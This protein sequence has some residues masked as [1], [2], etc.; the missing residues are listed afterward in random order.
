MKSLCTLESVLTV[1][2]L[3][4][5]FC[6]SAIEAYGSV[7]RSVEYLLLV[8]IPPCRECDQWAGL[9]SDDADWLSGDGHQD[10]PHQ[11]LVSS[12]LPPRSAEESNQHLLWFSS[13]SHG[14]SP[15]CQHHPWVIT[16]VPWGYVGKLR[17]GPAKLENGWEKCFL[18]P[19]GWQAEDCLTTEFKG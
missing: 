18:P 5:H 4:A 3:K 2:T 9:R 10:P 7:A 11:K 12:S 14:G 8:C 13:S 15:R 6:L 1:H 16:I 17:V 19:S